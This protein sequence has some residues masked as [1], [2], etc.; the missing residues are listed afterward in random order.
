V[1]VALFKNTQF[2]YVSPWEKAPRTDGWVQIS[3]WA[4]VEFP[5][6]S[7]NE[8]R[9]SEELLALGKRQ[10]AFEQDFRR[11]KKALEDERAAL[12]KTGT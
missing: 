8:K 2:D 4:E 6:L 11:Q 12:L 3:G 1:K 7:E 9:I 5:P 10:V